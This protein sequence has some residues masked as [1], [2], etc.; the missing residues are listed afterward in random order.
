MNP[1]LAKEF[2]AL[3][4]PWSLCA[5]ASLGYLAGTVSNGSVRGALT[6]LAG[7]AFYLGCLLLAVLPLGSEFQERT[8]PLLFGPPIERARLWKEKFLAATSAVLALV[9]VH[10][11]MAAA[12]GQRL[13]SDDVLPCL[14]FVVATICSAGL[15]TLTARSVIGGMVLAGAGQFAAIGAVTG[16]IYLCYKVVGR[17]PFDPEMDKGPVLTTYI[18][19]GAIYSALALWLGWRTFAEMEVRDASPSANLALPDR[20]TPR[21]LATLFRCQPTGNLRNLFRKEVG[22]QKPVFTIAAVFVACW[23]VAFLLL[24]LEPTQQQESD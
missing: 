23:V 10:G 4:F 14:G 9:V 22:L 6:G 18:C 17:D 20:F 3:L 21:K 19:A 16:A 13:Q 24:L 15:L 7:F 11:V 12:A 1:R 2:R 8:L 5:I